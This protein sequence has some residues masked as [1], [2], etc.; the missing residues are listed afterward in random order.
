LRTWNTWNTP[1]PIPPVF[2]TE[3]GRG[4]PLGPQLFKEYWDNRFGDKYRIGGSVRDLVIR[5]LSDEGSTK[6]EIASSVGVSPRQ[7][8]RIVNRQEET[9]VSPEHESTPIEPTEILPP[10]EETWNGQTAEYAKGD[11]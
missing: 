2:V 10:V 11:Y 5:Q 3:D 7:I 6:R 9:D 4:G 8:Q 1:S